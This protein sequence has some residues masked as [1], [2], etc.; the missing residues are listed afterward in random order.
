MTRLALLVW[1]ILSIGSTPFV[2]ADDLFWRTAEN[3]CCPRHRAGDEIWI[4]SSRC[5]GHCEPIDLEKL[6]G[7]EWQAGE[8][9]SADW[10]R[11]VSNH[12][13]ADDKRTVI[14][15]HGNRTDIDWSAKRGLQVFDCVFGADLNRSDVR[16]VIWSWPTDPQHHRLKEYRKNSERSIWEGQILAEFLNRLGTKSPIGIIG[17]SFGA[18]AVVSASEITCCESCE[19]NESCHQF[20]IVLLAPALQKPWINME[21]PLAASAECVSSS[22][23]LVNSRDRAL[24]LHRCLT[25]FSSGSYAWTT[26]VDELATSVDGSPEWD[27]GRL[28][29]ARHDVARYVSSPD[30]ASQIRHTTLLDFAVETT[31]AP[32]VK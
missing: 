24:K 12:R 7:F 15:L 14:F 8:W 20:G 22:I 23:E 3:G 9:P 13:E 6:R 31:A 5:L 1:L 26:G 16:F 27:I 17:Y 2:S 25:K 21:S 32:I 4:V 11:L 10:H 28:V 18:Q 29:G 30:V 19:Q